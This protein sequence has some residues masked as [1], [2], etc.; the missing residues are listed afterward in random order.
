MK[1]HIANSLRFR[2]KLRLLLALGFIALHTALRA[3]DFDIR[4]A[5][6]F[7]KIVPEGAELK[8][9]AGGMKFLEGPVWVAREEGYLIFSNIPDAELKKWSEQSGLSTFREH[10]NEANGNCVDRQGR[11][12]SCEGEARRVTLTERDGTI[13]VLADQYDGKKFNSPNDVV[14]KSDG[15]IW[16]SDPDY[17]L[18]KKT[19]EAD[20]LYIYRLDPKTKKMAVVVKDCDKP[21][22]LCFSPDEKLLYV[23]DSGKPHSIRV[24]EVQRDDGLAHGRVFCVIDKG[25]P[26]GIRCDA[27]GRVFSS[28]GDGVQIFNAGGELIGKILVP[29]SPANLAFGGKDGK[30]LYITARSSLY[31]IPLLVKG[32]R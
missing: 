21:N 6:E 12:I 11:L 28:A 16:F 29:E 1:E 15:T 5:N 9:L 32:A 4:I 30:T 13:R 3:G 23:A 27:K 20:G 18:R 25:V 31:S 7:Q 8:K 22:G 26:D 2:A 24:Y 10:S 17:A 14:V 19:R